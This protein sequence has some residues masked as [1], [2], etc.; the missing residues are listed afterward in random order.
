MTWILNRLVNII[1]NE[2][3]LVTKGLLKLRFFFKFVSLANNSKIYQPT[4]YPRK[5]FGIKPPS[6]PATFE[7]KR[8][9]M[10]RLEAI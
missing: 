8:P 2:L 9:Y 10:P 6:N 4:E 5:V 3:K 1:G 7:Q